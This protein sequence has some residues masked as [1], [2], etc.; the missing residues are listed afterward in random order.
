[1]KDDEFIIDHI[2]NSGCCH[3][4]YI[5]S[6]VRAFSANWPYITFSGLENY[7]LLINVYNQKVL[8]RIQFAPLGE[9]VMVCQTFISNTK[10]LFLVIKKG[11]TFEVLMICLDE[12]NDRGGEDESVFKFTKILEYASE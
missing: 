9:N 4:S 10:D 3:K 12:L 6:S 5:Y 1:M 2:D 11:N 7:L 8:H